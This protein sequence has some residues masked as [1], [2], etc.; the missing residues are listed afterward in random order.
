MH[1]QPRCRRSVDAENQ[2]CRYQ[3]CLPK[4]EKLGQWT[5][6]TS[7]SA[8]DRPSCSLT[9]STRQMDSL[10]S[11]SQQSQPFSSRLHRYYMRTRPGGQVVRTG[12]SVGQTA[13]M[14]TGTSSEEDWL[15]IRP[16]GLLRIMMPTCQFTDQ[17]TSPQ[18][19]NHQT[20]RQHVT[21]I[22]FHSFHR[23]N[24]QTSRQHVTFILLGYTSWPER[25]YMRDVM[26]LL[27]TRPI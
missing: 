15:W 17:Q 18:P 25:T 3:L 1:P 10:A 6:L 14:T 8:F 24:H 22:S 16:P 11:W 7:N 19:S 21:F 20:S 12:S 13:P 23:P 9:Q 2:A 27:T 26:Y 4:C 5:P